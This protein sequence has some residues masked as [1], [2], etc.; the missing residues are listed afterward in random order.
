MTT[1]FDAQHHYLRLAML[2]F[3]VGLPTLRNFFDQI[4]VEIGN[5]REK[6]NDLISHFHKADNDATTFVP[7]SVKEWQQERTFGWYLKQ[8]TPFAKGIP[9]KKAKNS[10]KSFLFTDTQKLAFEV[11]E[12]FWRKLFSGRLRNISKKQFEDEKKDFTCA[13]KEF[14]KD[15]SIPE[16]AN[17][18][19][20]KEL[21][22]TETQLL[23]HISCDIWKTFEQK[24]DSNEGRGL[25]DIF[26]L[27][28]ENRT[29]N[30]TNSDVDVI[31]AFL[32]YIGL[33]W[34]VYKNQSNATG[35]FQSLFLH[36][37]NMPTCPPNT[38]VTGHY[39]AQFCLYD[40]YT[41]EAITVADMLWKDRTELKKRMPPN[42]Q[43][44]DL[45][46]RMLAVVRERHQRLPWTIMEQ[47]RAQLVAIQ[48]TDE[49]I[50]VNPHSSSDVDIKAYL[51]KK[52]DK[53]GKDKRGSTSN[54]IADGE[55]TEKK[56]KKTDEKNDAQTP[57]K[58]DK[59]EK[60]VTIQDPKDSV[61]N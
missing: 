8:M 14:T 6:F 28:A 13:L 29:S 56:D 2:V 55:K 42:S 43:I 51:K 33:V 61:E 47:I 60:K 12:T 25:K 22:S 7:V 1:H 26:A 30:L 32:G 37:F 38:P 15:D 40:D 21:S 54:L 48:D 34:S 41:L 59:K 49:V 5:S 18:I 57:K 35:W 3:D 45:F 52:K 19:C 16:K 53:K 9:S 24:E 46:S 10:V 31:V 58:S 27:L 11:L 23:W 36:Y 17:Q 44:G 4:L 39:F 50:I 20:K